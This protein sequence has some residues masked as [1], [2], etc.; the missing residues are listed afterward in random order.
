MNLAISPKTKSV[1]VPYRKDVAT[2]LPEAQRSGSH[3]IVNHGV[4]ETKL[5]RNMGMEVPAPILTQYQWANTKP[6]DSQRV[7][8]AMFTNSPRAYCLSEMGVGKSR[9]G[10][11]AYDFLRQE[12][13]VK[14][15]LIV[16]PLSTL[17]DVWEREIFA[18]FYH[19]NCAVLHGTREQRLLSLSRDVDIYI[20]N[21]DGIK[22]IGTELINKKF[23]VVIIDELAEYRN[24][25]T[26]RWKAM[27]ALVN[28]TTWLPHF[29]W[30]L[31]GSPTPNGP[32]DAFGQ[33][34]L[35]TPE[36]IARSFRTFQRQIMHQI[37][38]FKWLPK[39]GANDIVAAAMKPSVRFSID[40]HDLPETTYSSRHAPLTAAQKRLYE[41]M[42]R[43]F[44][45][46]LAGQ[47]IV[48]LNEGVK[49]TK[50]LQ[51]SAGFAYTKDKGVHINA[52]ERMKVVLELIEQSERKVIVF[53]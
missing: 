3:L 14:K 46:E 52:K 39:P 38:T 22:I 9:A 27:N 42:L 13:I 8:A 36:N 21:P 30:G 45:M 41:Q 23:D 18:S 11:Y 34:K 53:A 4:V 17:V 20:I 12:K 19:L 40:E 44:K 50:L 2:L 35:L 26:D 29:V 37:S 48:A 25:N 16:A 28:S 15:M 24:A 7:T 43:H 10:L 32:T 49:L 1:V 6:F 33:V 47:Q 5:L 31:T 51:I